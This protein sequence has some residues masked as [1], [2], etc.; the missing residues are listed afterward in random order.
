MY[1]AEKHMIEIRDNRNEE[2]V[3]KHT[4][5]FSSFSAGY[6]V[7]VDESSHHHVIKNT[8]IINPLESFKK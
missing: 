3:I 5:K 2:W 6:Y 1:R 7:S 4:F 8:Q